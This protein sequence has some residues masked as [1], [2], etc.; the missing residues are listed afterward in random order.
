MYIFIYVCICFVGATVRVTGLTVELHY[1]V[2]NT[3][4]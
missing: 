1:M 2:R 3:Y 4:I